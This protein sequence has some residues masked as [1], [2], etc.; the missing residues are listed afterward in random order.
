MVA[1]C[2][3]LDQLLYACTQYARGLKACL[4]VQFSPFGG[5]EGVDYL[6]M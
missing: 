3:E 6:M 4:H 1:G 5:C 2:K